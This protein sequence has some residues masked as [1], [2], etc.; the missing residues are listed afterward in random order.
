M[1]LVT[2]IVAL[3]SLSLVNAKEVKAE[4]KEQ[5]EKKE[6]SLLFVPGP[7]YDPQAE[8]GLTLILLKLFKI[9]KE[10]EISP[11]STF[12]LIAKGTTNDSLMGGVASKL[13]FKKDKWRVS[14][15]IF[16]GNFVG[17]MYLIDT[18]RFID[19]NSNV[20]AYRFN[21][22]MQV[23]KNLYL[24]L[25][26]FTSKIDFTP[27]GGSSNKEKNTSISI[28][29]DYDTKD[30][31]FAT[32]SGENASVDLHLFRKSL[33]NK[34][35]FE[36]ITLT[37]TK[38]IS[39]R[40]NKNRHLAVIADSSFRLGSGALNYNYKYGNG[41]RQRGYTGRVFEGKNMLRTEIEYKHFFESILKERFGIATFAGIGT[42][43][44]GQSQVGNPLPQKLK[45]APLLPHIG[46]GP[47]YRIVPEKNLN[48]R[49][50]FAYGREKEFTLYFSL[51]E[52]I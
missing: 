36:T 12:A 42:V 25:G 19:T 17:E 47:R 37:Y 16:K 11:P 50:D 15:A 8:F 48:T 21:A 41:G 34:E 27:A 2:I 26:S 32:N 43:Y 24:G 23:Y 9:D 6:K 38:Y 49:I 3:L 18:S 31:Q 20:F 40:G 51:S 33:G 45:D 1:K 35:D 46:F 39:L 13:F 7:S 52:A 28:L 22:Q 5:E 14:Y 10:D 29:S 30:N 4:N 44:G